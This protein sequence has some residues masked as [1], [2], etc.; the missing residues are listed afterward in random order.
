VQHNGQCLSTCPSQMYS[1][2]GICTNCSFPCVNCTH[3]YTCTSCP[4]DYLLVA[5]SSCVPGPTCPSG[6]YLQADAPKC[7]SKCPSVYYNLR[8]GTCNNISCGSYFMGA[9]M[10]CY[11]S[12]PTGYIANSSYYCVNCKNCGGLYFSLTY[13]IIKDSLYLYLSFTEIP[14]YSFSPKITFTPALPY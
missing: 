9:D 5:S 13:S 7:V 6:Y 3:A 14:T 2:G 10:F 1:L 8:N 11:S 4:T 12:C